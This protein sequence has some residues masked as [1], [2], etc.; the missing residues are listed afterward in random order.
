MSS[1]QAIAEK[2]N[3]YVMP[4]YA[5][6]LALVKGKGTKVWDADGKVY[7][8]FAAGISVVNVGHCNAVVTD[9]IQRQAEKLVHVSNLYYTE[10][11]AL[12]AEKIVS[13]F[14][15]NAKCFFANSGAEANEGLVKLAR[16]WGH[17]T[18]RYEVITMLQSFHGRTLATAAATG[19]A[20]VRKGFDPMPEGF[21]HAEYNNLESVKSCI[22]PQTVAI[23]LEALQGEGGVVPAEPAFMT[24]V[25]ALCKEHNL[26]LLCDEVQ[27]GLGRT[28]HWFGWQ[29]YADVQPDAFSLAKSLGNGYPIGAVVAGPKLADVFQPG[30]HAST[31]GGTPLACAAALA[32]LT[33]LENSSLVGRARMK[34][35]ELQAGL[36]ACVDK[37]AHVTAVRGRGLMLGLVLD[38][39]AK[40]LTDRLMDEGLLCIPTA[41]NVLRFL[42]PL[43]VSDDEIGEALEILDDCLAEWHG[44]D[45]EAEALP[46][47]ET[48]EAEAPAAA[49]ETPAAE[50]PTAQE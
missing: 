44:L 4:T 22:G 35:S 2:F 49:A 19:Q 41:G 34:G 45:T 21:V 42:P 50:P 9:A 25:Q 13:H 3:T 10:N 30:N 18:G 16:L 24:G 38:Q 46:T 14:T 39:D 27:C 37:Y 6:K 5:P 28:G 48:P 7:L 20:K 32:T 26:L 36:Q 15:P 23:M 31:F 29:A 17:D 8:D 12:L 1:T 40:P 43:T 11:Q 33:V 47:A